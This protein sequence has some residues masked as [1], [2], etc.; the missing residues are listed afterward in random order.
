MR[1]CW[2]VSAQRFSSLLTVG[3]VASRD[4]GP[5]R[6]YAAYRG[7]SCRFASFSSLLASGVPAGVSFPTMPGGKRE[8]A[9][10]PARIPRAGS[11]SLGRSARRRK[12]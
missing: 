3:L 10:R 9:G 6:S 2:H 5:T 4:A 8:G 7:P 12:G 1:T 11:L